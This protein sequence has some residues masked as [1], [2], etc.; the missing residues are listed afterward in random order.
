MFQLRLERSIT[1]HDGDARVSGT[2]ID[3]NNILSLEDLTTEGVNGV[4]VESGDG[5][6]ELA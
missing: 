3:S 4:L 6:D 1:F 2:E 5:F